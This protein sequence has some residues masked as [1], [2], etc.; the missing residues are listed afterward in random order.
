MEKLTQWDS[1]YGW[2]GDDAK[3][4]IIDRG[5]LV[6]SG[7]DEASAWADADAEMRKIGAALSADAKAYEWCVTA[8]G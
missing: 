1:R 6:G 4:V 2:A 7:V 8:D 5:L 3:A